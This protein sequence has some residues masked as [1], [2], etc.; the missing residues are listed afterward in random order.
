M[1]DPKSSIYYCDHC[2]DQG[3]KTPIEASDENLCR[4]CRAMVFHI[5]ICEALGVDMSRQNVA[6]SERVH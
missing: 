5:A 1:K 3:K 6:G 4:W 2:H